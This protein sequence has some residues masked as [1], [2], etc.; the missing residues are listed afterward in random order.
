MVQQLIDRLLVE[1]QA[2]NEDIDRAT[3]RET[4]LDAVKIYNG[5]YSEVQRVVKDL[6]APIADE[7]KKNKSLSEDALKDLAAKL[8]DF[9]SKANLSLSPEAL[10]STVRRFEYKFGWQSYTCGKAGTHLPAEHPEI[11]KW[12][13]FVKNPPKKRRVHPALKGNMDIPLNF[14]KTSNPTSPPQYLACALKC[15]V[16]RAPPSS[17][18]CPPFA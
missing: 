8:Q 12:R 10:K 2:V 16:G 17:N 18:V 1:K 14:T 11:V 7:I 4:L 13:D 9:P 5:A 6:N 15:A 3:I